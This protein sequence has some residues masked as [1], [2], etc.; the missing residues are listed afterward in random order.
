MVRK[1]IV[2]VLVTCLGLAVLFPW[3]DSYAPE[4][5]PFAGPLWLL[6]TQAAADFR[7]GCCLIVVLV[8]MMAAIG[9]KTNAVTVVLCILGVSL[10]IA[11]GILLGVSAVV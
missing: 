10:W 11:V 8:P 5:N 1:L 3:G 9:I 4:G 6:K 7:G 2:T